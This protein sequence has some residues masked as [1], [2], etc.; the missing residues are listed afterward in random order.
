MNREVYVRFWE[1]GENPRAIDRP[2]R[3]MGSCP[4]INASNFS[5]TL[6]PC[7]VRAADGGK[8]CCQPSEAAAGTVERFPAAF[9][10]TQQFAHRS[11]ESLNEPLAGQ[12]RR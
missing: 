3:S 7:G 9:D 11:H 8:A 2:K 1:A 10:R 4:R 12:C 6:R 5:D